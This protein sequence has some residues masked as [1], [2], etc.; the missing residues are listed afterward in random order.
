MGLL[1]GVEGNLA[2]K[3]KGD[4]RAGHLVELLAIEKVFG[5]Q[6]VKV[7]KKTMCFIE[8]KWVVWKTEFELVCVVCLEAG[9]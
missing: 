7:E 5:E 2:L 3:R 1:E 8:G 6:V 9:C 4:T